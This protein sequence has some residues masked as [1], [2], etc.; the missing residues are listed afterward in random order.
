VGRLRRASKAVERR[1]DV[2][3]TANEATPKAHVGDALG[4]HESAVSP[5]LESQDEGRGAVG[6]R[7]RGERDRGGRAGS[8]GS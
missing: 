3:D 8:K 6:Y 1:E 4:V 2:V 7:R 5:G